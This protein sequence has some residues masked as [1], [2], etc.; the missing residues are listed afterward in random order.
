METTLLLIDPDSRSAEFM[1][2]ALRKAG[3]DVQSVAS[4]KEGLIAAWRDQPDI[5]VLELALPDLDGVEIVRKLRADPRTERK[6]LVGLTGRSSP[7]ETKAGHEA[8][9]DHYLL[10]QPD[11][12]DLLLRTLAPHRRGG[13]G[14]GGTAPLQPGQLIA[15]ASARG[16]IGTS[17]LTMNLAF[18]SGRGRPAESVAAMDLSLPLGTLASMGGVEPKT[19]LIDLTELGATERMPAGFK[20]HLTWIPGWGIYLAAG[21]R[22]PRRA[23]QLRADALGPLLQALRATFDVTFVDIGRSLSRLAFLLFSQADL[24][25]FLVAPDEPTARNGR[26]ILRFLTEE[27]VPADRFLVVSNRPTGGEPM[28]GHDLE[29]QLGR[30]VDLAI[31][32]S[33]SHF[34]LASSLHA[35]F[36]LRFPEESATL[37]LRELSEKVAEKLRVPAG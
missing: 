26:H 25:V 17:T 20:R 6:L 34:A 12:L 33:G 9:L 36:A 23:T 8:G 21:P 31:P 35:P 2:V 29:N 5:I 24:V 22:D 30:T 15:M 27:G 16:G 28:V 1:Q 37:A 18:E 11:A 3:Y 13:L 4:G 14:A 10:K 19:D 32:N 7:E